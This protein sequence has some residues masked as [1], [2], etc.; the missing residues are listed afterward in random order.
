MIREDVE[1][2]QTLGVQGTPTY[3]V[4]GVMVIGALTFEE[5]KGLVEKELQRAMGVQR[6]TGLSGEALYETLAK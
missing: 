3:F 2:G 5:F 1:L 6:D 4:N